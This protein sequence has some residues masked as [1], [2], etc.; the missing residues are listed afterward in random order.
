MLLKNDSD[1]LVSFG[2]TLTRIQYELY[3]HHLRSLDRKVT[4][5]VSFDLLDIRCMRSE[6]CYHYIIQLDS[7][8]L[9]KQ[10]VE[11]C[12]PSF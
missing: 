10:V 6:L 12:V 7:T 8:L 3:T 9:H 1:A 2:H 4:K 5:V 11:R